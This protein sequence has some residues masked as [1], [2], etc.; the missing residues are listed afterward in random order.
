MDSSKIIWKIITSI[1]HMIIIHYT[2]VNK[3]I[4]I[5]EVI[6]TIIKLST[7]AFTLGIIETILEFVGKII[8]GIIKLIITEEINNQDD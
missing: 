2:F 5:E 4:K 3:E 1:F 8:I 7:I 6:D